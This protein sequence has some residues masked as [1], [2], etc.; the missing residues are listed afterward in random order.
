M[1]YVEFY[2]ESWLI[3]ERDVESY[4]TQDF[5]KALKEAN[6]ETLGLK[7][8]MTVTNI[9]SGWR[10]MPLG[11]KDVM[12]RVV[13]Y[14]PVEGGIGEV[15]KLCEEAEV[16]EKEMQRLVDGWLKVRIGWDIMGNG[17]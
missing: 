7:W 15:E 13:C 14:C 6:D 8:V 11:K 9:R 17:D 16:F 2:L 10:L 4:D 12:F 1:Y 3:D 5:L